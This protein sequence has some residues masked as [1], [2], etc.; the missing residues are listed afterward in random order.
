MTIREYDSGPTSN[1]LL[2]RL[3]AK[4]APAAPHHQIQAQV[5]DG[6]CDGL[7]V[8]PELASHPPESSIQSAE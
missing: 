3:I 2:E 6:A 5:T 1:D 8:A 7:V 4:H